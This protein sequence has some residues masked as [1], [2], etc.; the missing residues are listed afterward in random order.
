MMMTF[1]LMMIGVWMTMIIDVGDTMMMSFRVRM[2]VHM[3]HAAF[4]AAVL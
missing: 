1:T 3:M 2:V 4:V